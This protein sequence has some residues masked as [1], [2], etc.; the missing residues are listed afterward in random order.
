MS[1]ITPHRKEIYSVGCLVRGAG[2]GSSLKET[3]IKNIEI[4]RNLDAVKKSSTSFLIIHAAATIV[5]EAGY[6][7]SADYTFTALDKNIDISSPEKVLDYIKNGAFDLDIDFIDNPDMPY[8]N[9]TITV[10][11]EVLLDEIKEV[12]ACWNE[13]RHE[14]DINEAFG[15]TY[16]AECEEVAYDLLNKLNPNQGDNAD[17]IAVVFE[18]QIRTQTMALYPQIQQ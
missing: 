11:D 2:L 4:G 7:M 13:N 6:E 16:D 5:F 15:F 14:H 8:D 1:K 12:M 3:V 10:Y 18:S 17:E 9:W